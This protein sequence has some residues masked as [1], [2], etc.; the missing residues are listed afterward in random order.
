MKPTALLTFLSRGYSLRADP[1]TGVVALVNPEGI[2]GTEVPTEIINELVSA[3]LLSYSSS[4]VPEYALTEKA[5]MLLS[6][7]L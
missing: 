1:S 3:G 4:L 6:M 5:R 2:A 7:Q